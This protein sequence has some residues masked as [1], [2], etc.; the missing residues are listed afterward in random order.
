MGSPYITISIS[1]YDQ[2]I[3]SY[4]PK[5]TSF[6]QIFSYRSQD[7]PDHTWFYYPEPVNAEHY[8]ELTFKG[9]DDLI[10]HL[11]AQY[12][13]LLPKADESTVSKT[14][15]NSVPNPPMVVATL[16]SNNVQLLLTGLEVQRIQHAYMHVSP[17]N[18]DAG[19]LS[20]LE[21]MDAKVLIA[22]NVFYAR[23]E[24]LA[25]QMEDFDLLA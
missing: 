6:H 8:R 14:T 22:D 2:L 1:E 16:G 19:I 20:L 7:Q 11:A 5:P 18:S 24:A 21:S 10:N 23:A 13:T 4:H 25:A 3:R 9:T 12:S 15:P 17:L